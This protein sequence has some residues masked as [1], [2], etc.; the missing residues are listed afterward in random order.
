MMAR[1]GFLDFFANAPVSGHQL[2]GW[3]ALLG[4]FVFFLFIRFV[5][6]VQ[7]HPILRKAGIN[8]FTAVV[9]VLFLIA[10]LKMGSD[11]HK[12]D[13][14]HRNG[15]LAQATVTRKFTETR[16]LP[17][18]NSGT[19][20]IVAYEYVDSTG[21][22]H[23]GEDYVRSQIWNSLS[24]GGAVEIK[25]LADRPADSA[26]NVWDGSKAFMFPSRWLLSQAARYCGG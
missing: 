17:I 1:L 3:Y 20:Y 7:A 22:K 16:I 19:D 9:G 15:V 4:L 13:L 25:Y 12:V 26:V 8:Q 6:K 10:L 23:S 11:W 2:Y 14:Y 5:G 18:H 21:T 24:A